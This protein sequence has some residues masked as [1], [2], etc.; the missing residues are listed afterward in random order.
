MAEIDGNPIS[1]PVSLERDG[2][3]VTSIRWLGGCRGDYCVQVEVYSTTSRVV[4]YG[5]YNHNEF[6]PWAYKE[7]STKRVHARTKHAAELAHAAERAHRDRSVS[8]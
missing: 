3:Q 2:E 7:P 4:V 6:G 1:G 8:P 5:G